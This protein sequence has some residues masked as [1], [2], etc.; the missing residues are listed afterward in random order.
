MAPGPV[1]VFEPLGAGHD[2]ASF[3]CG[4]PALDEYLRRRAGQDLRR[5]IARIFVAIDP[6]NDRLAGYYT[7][8]AAS[9]FREDLPDK[10]AK[11]LPKYPVPTAILGRLAVDQTYQG[12]GLRA[13]MLADAIKRL[14]RASEAIAIYALIVD[15]K[16]EAAKAFYAKFGFQAFPEAPM[17]LF[18][19]LERV[20]ASRPN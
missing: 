1:V 5:N 4:D 19:P 9:F 3:C 10:L 16:N 8:S 7:L 12:Q 11:R 6:S 15:A 2:R 17:R 14:I 13:L 18:L 20:I